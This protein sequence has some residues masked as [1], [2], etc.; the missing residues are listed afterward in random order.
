MFSVTD[1]VPYM[2][3]IEKPAR[4]I[5]QSKPTR[6]V[7]VRCDCPLEARVGNTRTHHNIQ[8]INTV[9]VIT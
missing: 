4:L 3:N 9:C 1:L 2:S 8:P 5:D 6:C 7:R